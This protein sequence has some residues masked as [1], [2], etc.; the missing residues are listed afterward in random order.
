MSVAYAT[1]FGRN[2]EATYRQIELAGQTAEADGPALV[3]LLYDEA[4]RAL[5]GA[6]WAAEHGNYAMK[7][8]KVTRATAILFALEAGLD[9]TAGGTVAPALAKLYGGARHTVVTAAIGQ[10]PR[11]FRDVA[12]TLDEIGQAWRAVRAA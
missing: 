12:D 10:D 3:Q 11:P 2:P 4:I 9:F 6:A 5:R 7:S 8:D 1:A